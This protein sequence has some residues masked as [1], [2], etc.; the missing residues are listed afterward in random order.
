M[1]FLSITSPV[2]IK[3]S[4]LASDQRGTVPPLFKALAINP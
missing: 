3:R 2:P 1:V 4:R